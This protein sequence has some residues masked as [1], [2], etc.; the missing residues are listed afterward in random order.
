M[1]ADLAAVH[2]SR[3]RRRS[4]TADVARE[5]RIVADLY[6]QLSPVVD[7]T[8]TADRRSSQGPT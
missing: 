2:E 5:T 3:I 4:P 6:R 1:F 8:P 7:S